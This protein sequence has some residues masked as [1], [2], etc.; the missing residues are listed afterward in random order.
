MSR[1][2]VVPLTLLLLS[3]C[4]PAEEGTSSDGTGGDTETSSSTTSATTPT[5]GDTAGVC[6]PGQSQ[7]C[8]CDGGAQ[9]AEVCKPDGTGFGACV[10]DDPTGGVSGDASTSAGPSTDV[11]ITTEATSAATTD[12]TA[13]STDASTSGGSTSGGSTT[14][15]GGAC[16]DLMSFELVPGDATLSGG[17]ML[18][19][20]MLGEG[21]VASLPNPMMNNMG[22]VLYSPDI[23]CDDTWY[24]WVR[25]LDQGSNDSYFC[26]LDGEPNPKPIFEGDC[27]N[28]GN[29]YKWARLNWRDPMAQACMYIEDPWAPMWAAGVH[30]IEFSYRE[31]SAIGR[32]LL[33]NDMNLVPP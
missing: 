16:Q 20:S 26:T 19:M 11:T 17:W 25:A 15:Q 3:S 23:P 24:I 7:S 9:G 18:T 28:Q 14:G 2:Y 27:S 6:V 21:Q 30:E 22:S 13:S 32:I 8:V 10:C 1:A 33:T 12:V 31:S 4:K 29:S 5:S